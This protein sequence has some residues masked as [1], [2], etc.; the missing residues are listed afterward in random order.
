MRVGKKI[1][2]GVGILFIA[3]ETRA[4]QP[5]A[6]EDAFGVE[7]FSSRGVSTTDGS[8]SCGKNEKR[9]FFLKNLNKKKNIL[10]LQLHLSR[11][12]PG[13]YI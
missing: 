5:V 12:P 11:V 6:L 9:N 4:Q 8:W 13:K 2:D 10:L 1:F 3:T 7:I